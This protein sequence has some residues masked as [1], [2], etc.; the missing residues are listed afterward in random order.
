MSFVQVVSSPSRL[1]A[2]PTML[3]S[4]LTVL[5]SSASLH[6]FSPA[7]KVPLIDRSSGSIESWRSI[8]YQAFRDDVESYARH[9]KRTFR[10]DGISPKSVIGIWCVQ[11][12]LLDYSSPGL[13][14]TAGLEVLHTRMCFTSTASQEL[15]IFH[16]C[17]AYDFQTPT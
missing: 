7:F 8:S 14:L 5:E 17:S 1:S 4:H 13:T 16:S 9:W 15:V 11:H 3:R 10:R 6:S 12:K 2:Y